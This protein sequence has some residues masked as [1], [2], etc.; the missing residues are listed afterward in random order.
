MSTEHGLETQS[1]MGRAVTSAAA[2]AGLLHVVFPPSCSTVITLGRA[3]VTLGRLAAPG[4]R[5][6]A[7]RTVSRRHAEIGWSDG[8]HHVVDLGSRN[9]SGLDGRPIDGRCPLADGAVLRLGDTLAVYERGTAERDG[10]TI[11]RAALPGNARPV[12]R[13]R[14]LLARA[15]SDPAPALLIG[16][17]GTGKEY[18]AREIHRLSGRSGPFRAVNCAAL[19]PA[20]VESQLFGHR[21]GAFTGAQRDAPGLFR[22]AHEGTLLLDEIGD[23]PLEAQPKLL[24]VLQEAEVLP[25]GESR[26]VPVDV[27]IVAATLHPLAERVEAGLFRRDLYARLAMWELDVPPLRARRCDVLSWFERLDDTWRAARPQLDDGPIALDVNAA[28]HLLLAPWPENLR[29]LGR[30]VHRLAGAHG[31]RVLDGPTLAAVVGPL[32]R[33]VTPPPASPADSPPSVA[34]A[35]RAARPSADEL[36]AALE[37]LG[38]VRA[39][40]R[41]YQRERK[42]IYRWMDAYGLR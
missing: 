30:A 19:S 1:G 25:V 35:P 21:R 36:S 17:T 16:E 18:L 20:L 24:R 12:C 6:I 28:E 29:G 40:A 42:Q 7:H 23:L 4:I 22:D 37:S 8:A 27:R 2:P 11:D 3:S 34:A 13:L 26:P 5:A 10:P 33:P 38:S 15:A 31:G 9:G 41:H 32:P 39:V 14:R